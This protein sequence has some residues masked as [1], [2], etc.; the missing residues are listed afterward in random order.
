LSV[1]LLGFEC[2]GEEEGNA[3][4][5]SQYY[6]KTWYGCYLR[7]RGNSKQGDIIGDKKNMDEV[8]RAAVS[9]KTRR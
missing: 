2:E 1:G 4:I 3:H 6:M 5:L 8:P 9:R 7:F